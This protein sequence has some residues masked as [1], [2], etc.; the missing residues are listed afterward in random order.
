M[1]VETCIA[2]PFSYGK[3]LINASFVKSGRL[4]QRHNLNKH[5]EKNK[6]FYFMLVYI[7]CLSSVYVSQLKIISGHQLG[8]ATKPLGFNKKQ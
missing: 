3:N 8:S 5:I 2:A 7:A 4:G 6:P 1:S